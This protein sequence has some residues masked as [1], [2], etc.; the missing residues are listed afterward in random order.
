MQLIYDRPA[1]AGVEN[2]LKRARQLCQ[3]G[4]TPV[5]PLP[6]ALFGVKG[7]DHEYFYGYF[8]PW[9]PQ[10]GIPYSSCRTVEKYVGWNI[11]P[12]TF[13]TALQNPHSVVYT[14]QLKDE[15]GTKANSYYGLVCSMF[16]SYALELPYRIVCKD[17][18][19]LEDICAVSAEPLENLRLG[20][21]LLDPKRHVAL[22]TGIARD[23]AGAVQRIEVSECTLPLTV[24]TAFTPEEFRRFWLQDH[25]GVYRYGKIDQV[26]YTPDP[27]MPLEGE[28]AVEPP[29]FALLPDY[30]NKANYRV[31]DEAVELWALEEGWEAVEVIHPDGTKTHHSLQEGHVTLQPAAV[32]HYSACLVRDGARSGSVE[33]RMVSL[34]LQF[35]KE[36]Y[37]VGEPITCRTWNEVPGEKVFHAVLNTDTYYVKDTVFLAEEEGEAGRFALPAQTVP[38]KYIVIAMARNEYG[39][40]TS[41]YC[42][43]TVEEEGEQDGTHQTKE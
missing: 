25:Y 9:R 4:W 30:G 16:V 3:I 32:G 29:H 2:A 14:R 12:E 34:H 19:A 24:C 36:K 8:Q 26:T 42:E 31:G 13:L 1:S 22:I 15:P 41:P 20:D 28:M 40:Y 21:I 38:G 37:A 27:W 43:V 7:T 35:E 11:S 18:T 23:E 6:S 10:K 39:V 5:R 33:W 17:W